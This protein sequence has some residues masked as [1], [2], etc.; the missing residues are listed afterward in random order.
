MAERGWRWVVAEKHR[1]QGVG[2]L[3]FLED[4]PR[5]GWGVGG[6][7]GAGRGREERRDCVCVLWGRGRRPYYYCMAT[8]DEASSVSVL[9]GGEEEVVGERAKSGRGGWWGCLQNAVGVGG[10]I[11]RKGFGGTG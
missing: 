9:G 4:G 7:V 10:G 3:S 2:S 8:S 5:G 11:I 1:N 6:W